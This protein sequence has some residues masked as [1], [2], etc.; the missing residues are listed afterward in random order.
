MLVAAG[1]ASVSA[2]APRT[3][4]EVRAR[5][6]AAERRE[7]TLQA[8]A[9]LRTFWLQP[10]LSLSDPIVLGRGQFL[11]APVVPRPCAP[12]DRDS[13]R[14]MRAAPAPAR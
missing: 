7:C 5:T 9:T 4:D 13:A 2:R 11:G 3:P 6:S 8:E 14:T 1:C 12:A 10:V